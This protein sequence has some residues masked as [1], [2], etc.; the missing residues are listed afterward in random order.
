MEGSGAPMR[1]LRACPGGT[2]AAKFGGNYAASLLAQADAGPL[3]PECGCYTCRH[4]S[5]AYLR[6]LFAAG[7][8]TGSI[9]N[10][11]H[12]LA[13]YLDTMRLIREAIAFGTFGAFKAA[14]LRA[15]ASRP[16]AS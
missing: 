12:N 6:H 2:G 4:F 10:T 16:F 7:E 15:L 8:M 5:R 11:I 1:H 9:L 3:D 14:Y 13:F